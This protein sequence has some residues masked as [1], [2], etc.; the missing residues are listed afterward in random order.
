MPCREMSEEYAANKLTLRM[1]PEGKI[2]ASIREVKFLS[3]AG[4]LRWGFTHLIT[5]QHACVRC[6]Q[7]AH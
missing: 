7:G 3:P 2:D 6:F 4:L 5:R 1:E